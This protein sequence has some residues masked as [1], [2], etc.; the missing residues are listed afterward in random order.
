MQVRR[1]LLWGGFPAPAE[2]VIIGL[3]RDYIGSPNA[4]ILNYLSLMLI[5]HLLLFISSNVSIYT[6]PCRFM[7]ILPLLMAFNLQP[8]RK[9]WIC[10]WART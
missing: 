7:N 3:P 5:L 9:R 10:A 1:G 4:E 2:D 6:M 8:P